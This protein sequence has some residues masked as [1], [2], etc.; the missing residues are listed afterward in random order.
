MIEK[1]TEGY[2]ERLEAEAYQWVATMSS[3]RITD[4]EQA[5]FANWLHSDPLCREIYA[6]IEAIWNM[7]PQL[8]ETDWRLSTQLEGSEGY[9]GFEA[10][11]KR[12]WPM[13]LAASVLLTTVLLLALAFKPSGYSEGHLVTDI[14]E[15]RIYTLADGSEVTLGAKSSLE[16][17]YNEHQ[18]A[19]S[20]ES[21]E[22]F[23]SVVKDASRPFV[24]SV[25]G[26]EVKAVGTQFEVWVSDND[27]QVSVLEGVV[28]V[29]EQVPDIGDLTDTSGAMLKKVLL[30]ANQ[31]LSVNK[32]QLRMPQPKNMQEEVPGAWRDGRLMYESA[33]LSEVIADANRYFDSS[34]SIEGDDL[35]QL[36]VSAAFRTDQIEGMIEQLALSLSIQVR[37]LDDGR[38]ILYPGS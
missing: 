18:R 11:K 20:L 3:D 2:R 35:Q 30:S 38:M 4:Q 9:S 8:K 27:L 13:A 14:G 5:D 25:D 29:T 19:L 23:F 36:P 28:E 17:N 33:T 24:V 37:Y 10:S 7:I 6:E 22:A 34:I 15:V 32:N 31:K 26:K 16:V 1:I 21:G 12:Y